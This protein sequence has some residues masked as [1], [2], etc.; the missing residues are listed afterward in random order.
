ML[1]G[2]ILLFLGGWLVLS[3]RSI[4]KHRG[5]SGCCGGCKNETCSHR[6]GPS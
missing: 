2:L 6:K 3:I 5:C 4:Q 1:E